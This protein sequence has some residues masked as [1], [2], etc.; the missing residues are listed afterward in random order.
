[1]KIPK[2]PSIEQAIS[3]LIQGLQAFAN[4]IEEIL[5]LL[6]EKIRGIFE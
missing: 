4:E 1:M 3:M 2:L 6:I 5:E